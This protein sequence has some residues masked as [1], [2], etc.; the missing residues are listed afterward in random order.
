VAEAVDAELA[1][2]APL[3][4]VAELEAPASDESA[5]G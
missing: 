2:P 5:V 4:T 1:A 3:E